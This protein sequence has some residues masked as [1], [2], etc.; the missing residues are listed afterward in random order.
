V[1]GSAQ[2]TVVVGH[3]RS[4]LA[5]ETRR[6]AVSRD[7]AESVAADDPWRAVLD[8]QLVVLANRV[9]EAGDK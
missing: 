4:Q 2:L 5:D 9:R 8:R 3:R 7:I 6:L 1:V